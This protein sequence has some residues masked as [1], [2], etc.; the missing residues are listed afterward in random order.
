MS[1]EIKPLEGSNLSQTN[2]GGYVRLDTA[3]YV[4]LSSRDAFTH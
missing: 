3:G 4:E 1:E 2:T